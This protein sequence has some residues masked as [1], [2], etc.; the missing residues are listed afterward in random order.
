M[1]GTLLGQQLHKALFGDPQAEAAAKAAE[2]ARLQAELARQKAA[3]EVARQKAEDIKNKLLGEM[4]GVEKEP[5]LQM[6]NDDNLGDPAGINLNATPQLLSAQGEA[7]L[8]GFPVGLSLDGLKPVIPDVTASDYM[9]NAYQFL[10]DKARGYLSSG[11]SKAAIDAEGWAEVETGPQGMFM[12]LMINTTKLPGTIFPKI[13][14]AANGDSDAAN[15]LTVQSVNRLYDF[16]TSVN[17]GVSKGAWATAEDAA[18]D[19]ANGA[20]KGLVTSFI[21]DNEDTLKQAAGTAPKLSEDLTKIVK[22]W[23]STPEAGE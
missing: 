4:Q 5:E 18:E 20:V 1:L 11:A 14:D 2:A 7:Y 13:L 17:K 3:E 10:L 19:S 6:M 21:P 22:G 23:T 12:A 8:S 9:D 15:G 16:G